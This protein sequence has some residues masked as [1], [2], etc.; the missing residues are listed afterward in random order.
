M[1][2]MDRYLQ[3]ARIGKAKPYVKP[4]D[5]VLDIGSVDGVLFEALRGTIRRGFGID[6]VLTKTIETDLYTLIPGH[7]PESCPKGQTFDV[8]TLLAVLE[9][10]PVEAQKALAEACFAYLNPGGRVV[11]T[12]PSPRV[13]V[14]L[15]V[16]RAF[17]VIDG[18]SLEEHY[19][20][21]P[22]DTPTIFG[23]PRFRMFAHKTFQL[24]LNNLYVFEKVATGKSV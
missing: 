21:K 12:V 1:R 14:I 9:H 8:I 5:C 11:V 20:F 22:E 13:D 10:I 16:L 6:P 23:A 4:G 24:G 3:R 17:R 19:G 2:A 18:M 15:S 7:F